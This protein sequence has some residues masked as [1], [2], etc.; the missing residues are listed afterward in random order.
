[1]ENT[2]SLT[3][4]K[5][6]ANSAV[7]CGV[8]MHGCLLR[9]GQ[10]GRCRAR[11]CRDGQVIAGNYGKITSLALD[12][13]EKKP[14]NRFYPGSYVLSVGSYGCNLSCRFCQNYEI[15]QAGADQVPWREVSPEELCAYALAMKKRGNIGLAFT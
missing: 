8:C 11:I 14:L 1:M 6:A 12:P 15:A 3:N 2:K 5:E 9:E 4:D 13:I 10:T 7:Q